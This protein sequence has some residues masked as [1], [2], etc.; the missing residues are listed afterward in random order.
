MVN[1]LS[2]DYFIFQYKF[3]IIYVFNMLCLYL[4]LV[5]CDTPYYMISFTLSI[6]NIRLTSLLYAIPTNLSDVVFY[7]MG[8]LGLYFLL[9]FRLLWDIHKVFSVVICPLSREFNYRL[10]C[11]PFF[12]FTS[13]VLWCSYIGRR[14]LGS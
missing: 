7:L 2:S 9:N 12:A 6:T 14:H 3:N 11:W 1:S 5:Y 13:V 4:R 10:F 8:W